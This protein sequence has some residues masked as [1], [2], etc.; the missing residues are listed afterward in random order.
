MCS[1]LRICLWV[2]IR[3]CMHT[4]VCV[5]VVVLERTLDSLSALLTFDILVD[6]TNQSCYEERT[7]RTSLTNVFQV[8]DKVKVNET[9]MSI[10]YHVMH[11]S[12]AMR[13]LNALAEILFLSTDAL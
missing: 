13:S 1:C 7:S 3:A 12:T 9:N 11:K 10:Y 4:P 2:C 8:K 5:V 6:A